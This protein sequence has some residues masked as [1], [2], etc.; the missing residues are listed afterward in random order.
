MA[1]TKAAPL[2]PVV[3]AAPLAILKAAPLSNPKVALPVGKPRAVAKAAAPQP[4]S[5]QPAVVQV[6]PVVVA[7]VREAAPAVAPAP[8]FPDLK[9]SGIAWQGKGESSFAVVNGRAVLQGGVVDGF[10]VLEIRPDAVKFSG[11]NGTFEVPIGKEDQ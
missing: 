6:A 4:V 9:V 10:K 2:T 5:V 7:P 8:A 11:S 3:K 1:T